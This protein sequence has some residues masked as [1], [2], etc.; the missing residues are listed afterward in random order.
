MLLNT[1]CAYSAQ[2]L[3]ISSE[4]RWFDQ[5]TVVTEEL[6]RVTDN[7][8]RLYGLTDW[9][10]GTRSVGYE[11]QYAKTVMGDVELQIVQPLS[12]ISPNSLYL[13][14][15]GPGICCV[16]ENVPQEAWEERLRDYRLMGVPFLKK[17][18][19]EGG[20]TI[21]LDTMDILGGCLALRLD[22]NRKA[23]VRQDSRR[24]TQI[25][26]VTDDVDRTVREL[27]QLLHIGPWS[28]GTLNNR[29][30]TNPGILVD[31]EL[32]EPE[33]HFQLGITFYS[34]IEFEVIQPVK[35]P[36]VYQSYLDR[37]GCGFHHI[38]EVVP[39]ERWEE[40]LSDYQE[41][42]M[43][44]SIKGQVG[45][46]KFAYLDSEKDFDFVVE[47]GDG[48]PAIPL[49]EGYNEYAYPAD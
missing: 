11:E 17:E 1:D 46:T 2:E 47:L 20:E 28:I 21:W 49:P 29:S 30:V 9:S 3:Q 39:P 19:D 16:R 27:T 26:V 24:I 43:K 12:G 14:K 13:E 42:G 40:T 25:N 22:R 33:F 4:G 48:I 34:N 38:K 41:K 8:S 45:P 44:L 36:T 32:V 31:G 37:H 5:I 23:P 35:G 6:K 15:Y 10:R 7:L 18:E